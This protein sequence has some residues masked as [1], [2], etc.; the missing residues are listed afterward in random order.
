MIEKKN[1]CFCFLELVKQTF[2]I[3]LFYTSAT[4]LKFWSPFL[5]I[6]EKNDQKI[7]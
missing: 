4:N 1:S 5:N 2:F 6:R 3:Y 7:H